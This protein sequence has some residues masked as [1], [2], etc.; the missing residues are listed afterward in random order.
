[1]LVKFLRQS[2]IAAG[3]LL[4]LRLWLGWSWLTSGWGKA[5]GEERFD[6]SG[7]LHGAVQDP[8][9]NQAG[10][11][12]YPWYVAFI[13]YVALPLSSVFSF[14]V[15]WGE[16]FVGVGLILG[17]LT[18]YAAFFGATMNFAFLFA[19]TISTNPIMLLAAFFLIAAGHNG[20]W[21]GGDRYIQPKLQHW[22][23]RTS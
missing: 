20:G 10:E 5:L 2:A 7:Y 1:M 19:G 6:A 17:I 18:V 9:T 22:V 16:I 21:F 3:V 23:K 14:M 8:V 13:E 11:V 12:A 15:A 4:L